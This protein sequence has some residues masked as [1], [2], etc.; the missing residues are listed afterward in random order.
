MTWD[1]IQIY[2]STHVG[3]QSIWNL[4]MVNIWWF[5]DTADK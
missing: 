4:D 5:G 1:A 2:D 3:V